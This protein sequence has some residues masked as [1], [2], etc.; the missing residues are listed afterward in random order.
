MGQ[1]RLHVGGTH[2]VTSLSDTGL[3]FDQTECALFTVVAP[4]PGVVL[5]VSQCL[6][7]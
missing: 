5:E 3:Y 7:D 6:G 1:I 2:R 4:V